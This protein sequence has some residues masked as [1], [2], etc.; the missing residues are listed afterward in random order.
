MMQSTPSERLEAVKARVARAAERSGR[1][2]AEISLVAVT[3]TRPMEAVQALVQAG[4]RDLGE[5][6][7]DALVSRAHSMA[8]WLDGQPFA[9]PPAASETPIRWHMIGRL[10]RRQVPPLHGVVHR[11]HSVDSVALAERLSRTRPEGLPPLP[12]LVQCNTSG[13]AEKAGF[14]PDEAPD[15]LGEILALSGLAVDG[16][17]TMAPFTGDE[18]VIRGTFSALRELHLS[19]R[20]SLSDYGGGILSMGMSNDFEWAIEEGSTMIRV[21]SVLFDEGEP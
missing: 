19:L 3:K 7:V 1:N 10:Q 14:A 9:D 17:M 20:R 12:V 15:R 5:N 11:V 2:P 18:A 8:E 6:R 13:E 21:G 16:L 4:V